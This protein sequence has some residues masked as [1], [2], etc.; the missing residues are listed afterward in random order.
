MVYGHRFLCAITLEECCRT[1]CKLSETLCERDTL[2]KGF[3]VVKTV[4]D[5]FRNSDPITLAFADT[6]ELAVLLGGL[7]VSTLV[8]I[9]VYNIAYF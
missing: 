5:L 2:S 7:N 9:H 4:V 8:V 1:S 6:V 3:K